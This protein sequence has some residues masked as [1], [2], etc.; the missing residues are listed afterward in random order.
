MLNDFL[1]VMFK[2]WCLFW[3][4]VLAIRLGIGG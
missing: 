2:L 3:F 1:V 4:L